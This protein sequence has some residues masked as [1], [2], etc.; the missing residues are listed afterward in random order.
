MFVLVRRLL[1]LA[2]SSRL[3][4]GAALRDRPR[5]EPREVLRFLVPDERGRAPEASGDIVAVDV[6][7]G[8]T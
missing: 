6:T 3:G 5:P 4:G 7:K 1:C 2:G 8:S